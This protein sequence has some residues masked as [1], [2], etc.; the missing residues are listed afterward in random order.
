MAYEEAIK[1][2]EHCV[3]ENQGFC[4]CRCASKESYRIAIDC[5]EKQIPKKPIYT[6]IDGFTLSIPY[7]CPVCGERISKYDAYARCVLKEHH[8]KCGQAIDWS[9]VE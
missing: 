2:F 7:Y 8:C 6:F 5:I 9:E 4:E 1:E 3:E